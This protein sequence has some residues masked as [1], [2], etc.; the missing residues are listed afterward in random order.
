MR[1]RCKAHDAEIAPLLSVARLAPPAEG[2]VDLDC[3]HADRA[4]AEG[5]LWCLR[6]GQG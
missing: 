1:A 6:I 5:L 2:G 4:V 3:V